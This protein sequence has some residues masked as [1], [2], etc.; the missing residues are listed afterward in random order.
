MAILFT[1]I[2]KK[3]F[4]IKTQPASKTLFR[5]FNVLLSIPIEIPISEIIEGEKAKKSPL[6]FT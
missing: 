3:D 5:H 4:V 6:H 1:V 2:D